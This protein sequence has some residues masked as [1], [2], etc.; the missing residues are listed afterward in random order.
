MVPLLWRGNDEIQ[1]FIYFKRH[2]SKWNFV[3]GSLKGLSEDRAQVGFQP[4]M[5]SCIQ[6]KTF[7]I[8]LPDFSPS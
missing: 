7:F 2:F 8:C 3:L 1:N 5:W 6:K 4:F